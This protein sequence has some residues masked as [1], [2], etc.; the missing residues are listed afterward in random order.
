MF[1][2][3]KYGEAI[4]K[5]SKIDDHES[6]LSRTLINNDGYGMY[7]TKFWGIG[8]GKRVSDKYNFI[9]FIEQIDSNFN[10]GTQT[11]LDGTKYTNANTKSTYKH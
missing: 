4:S 3:I 5:T 1:V 8:L 7:G 2:D 10:Q 11:V 6:T 9:M